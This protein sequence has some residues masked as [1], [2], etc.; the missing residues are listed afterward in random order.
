MDGARLRTCCPESD[1][2]RKRIRPS[3]WNFVPSGV[4]AV[5]RESF[6]F[7]FTFFHFSIENM[8]K[9]NFWLSVFAGLELFPPLGY[10][11]DGP[12]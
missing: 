8:R 11:F 4:L 5:A 7:S 10:A 9:N 2:C 3:F 1:W 6:F 12:S